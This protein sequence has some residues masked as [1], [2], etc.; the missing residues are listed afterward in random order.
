MGSAGQ[1]RR[2]NPR[3]TP[4]PCPNPTGCDRWPWVR[5]EP[6]P[7]G[8]GAV[9]PAAA[10]R[11]RTAASL[12]QAIVEFVETTYTQAATLGGWDRAALERE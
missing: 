4:M 1:R 2:W 6:T 7:R 5:R 9:P 8:H 10:Q 12:E 3:S 11:V